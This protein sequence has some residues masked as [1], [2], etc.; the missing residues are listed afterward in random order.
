MAT[1]AG[2]HGY[3][4]VAPPTKKKKS[5]RRFFA[6]IVFAIKKIK[7]KFTQKIH[8]KELN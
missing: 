6:L 1:C 4:C 3:I 8:P 5:F 7:P 2:N